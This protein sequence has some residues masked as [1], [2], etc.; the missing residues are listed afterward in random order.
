M[1]AFA[2]RE[3]LDARRLSRWR[4]RLETE[5]ARGA[6]DA[7]PEFVELGSLRPRDVPRV[8]VVLRSGRVLRVAETIDPSALV[9]LARALEED[10][11]C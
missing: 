6:G 4:L 7:T 2:M 1:R 10:S 9:R 5:V 3:G 8:E 11:P